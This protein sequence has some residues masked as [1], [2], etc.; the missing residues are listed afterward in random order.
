LYKS[1]KNIQ[2]YIIKPGDC[3]CPDTLNG[4]FS[5]SPDKDLHALGDPGILNNPL[6]GLICS[7]QCPGSIII[8]TFDIVRALRDKP[9]VM[10]G[11]FHSP[12]ERECLE[13]L[14]RGVHPVIF[15]P[16]RGLNN[17][18]IGD[19]AR[20]ALAEGR[21]LVISAFG[22][23]VRRATASQA[24]FRNDLV[25]ALSN[26]IFVPHASPG[27]KTR[28]AVQKALAGGQEVFT[29]ED[30]ANA[31]LIASG[32]KAFNKD[33]IFELKPK[34]DLYRN[35]KFATKKLISL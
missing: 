14:L 12:M 8:K 1:R 7:V 34:E 29:V 25:A 11:G 32:A 33:Q 2:R 23:E 9:V 17:L 13:L 28:D 26:T 21:L 20:K 18:R 35:V 22:D 5:T 15:C 16:A 10:I 3:A 24:V 30:E 31:E 4:W 27:G 6:L 19:A